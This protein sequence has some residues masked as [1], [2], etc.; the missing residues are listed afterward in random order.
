MKLAVVVY[1]T[2]FFLLYIILNLLINFNYSI[3]SLTTKIFKYLIFF[4]QKKNSF[5]KYFSTFIVNTLFTLIVLNLI[6]KSEKRFIH[7]R[8]VK[9]TENLFDSNE[10]NNIFF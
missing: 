8:T 10:S 4:S 6:L 5:T 1:F 2:D 9:H 3:V 7:T